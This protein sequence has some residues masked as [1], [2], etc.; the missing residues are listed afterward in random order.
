MEKCKN[1]AG[2]GFVHNKGYLNG[3]PHTY[4]AGKFKSG[5]LKAEK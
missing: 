1:C 3:V 2:L 5:K 4:D